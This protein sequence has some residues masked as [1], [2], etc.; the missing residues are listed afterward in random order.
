MLLLSYG[1]FFNQLTL[2]QLAVYRL[3][4]ADGESGAPMS[5]ATALTVS[6]SGVGADWWGTGGVTLPASVTIPAGQHSVDFPVQGA[7]FGGAAI[8]ATAAGYRTATDR[9][10]ISTAYMAVRRVTEGDL[11]VGQRTAVRVMLSEGPM[12]VATTFTL[13]A[14]SNVRFT[15]AAG[16]TITSFTVPATD[17]TTLDPTTLRYFYSE[18]F[19]LEGLAAGPAT[20]GI[21]HPNFHAWPYGMTTVV[22]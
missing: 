13:T 15:D 19:Y 8:T 11:G 2:G 12:G 4:V 6:L 21:S 5:P 20:Y 17:W 10:S 16:N 3:E 1:P 18:V 22:P 14:S 7:A 9:I